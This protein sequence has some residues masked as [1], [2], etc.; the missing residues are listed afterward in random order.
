MLTVEDEFG[1]AA[2]RICHFHKVR[3]GFGRERLSRGVATTRE[4]EEIRGSCGTDSIH[5][6][7]YRVH[8]SRDGREVMGLV[9]DTEYDTSVTA[10][11][12]SNLSP[13]A[14]ELCV[15]WTALR[16]DA[17]VPASIVVL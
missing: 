6:P 8:P 11:F 12:L 10:V 4:K 14:L 3:A 9:H 13:D 2:Q 15:G 1:G 17:A 7:L 16:D 5:N